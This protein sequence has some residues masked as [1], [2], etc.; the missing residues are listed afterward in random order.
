MGIV[1]S[2]AAPQFSR[3]IES[4]YSSG[5]YY[6]TIRPYSLLTGIFPFSLAELIVV[7]LVLYFI[8]KAVRAVAALRTNP[9]GFATTV[10]GKGKRLVLT[11]A[12]VYLAFSFMW[13]FNYSRLTFAEISG[14]PVEPASVEEL[15]ELATH[16]AERA[17]EL[18]VQ[19]AEDGRGVMTL[20][21][22]IREMFGRAHLGYEKAAEIYPQLGGRYGRPKGVMLSRYWSYTGIGGMYFPFTA[23]ANVNTNL[24]HFLIPFTTTHEMAHQR[25]FAREDE[26]NYIAYLTSTLH[27]DVDFQYSGTLQA[28]NY[29]MSALRRYDPEKWSEVRTTYGEG[30]WRDLEEWQRYRARYDGS[31]RQVSTRVNNTYLMANRQTDGVHS[32]GRMVDL[33]L[34]EYRTVKDS[35]LN[36]YE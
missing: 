10:P 9:R 7:S 28:L 8:Y 20:N 26:A 17:N 3:L 21:G 12:V 25:G 1:F 5:I 15:T 18:R 19:V 24:P 4:R 22:D 14:L 11:L 36:E 32:Y 27:P 33:M 29:T 16:L 30:V 13:G 31:V 2:L 6:W 23:E 34:A 35:R